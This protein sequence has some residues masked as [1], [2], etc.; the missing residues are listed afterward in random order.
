KPVVHRA[1]GRLDRVRPGGVA[2][3]ELP[4]G[5]NDVEHPVEEVV[6]VGDVPVEGHRL[7]TELVTE[8]PHR[9]RL[10]ARPGGELDRGL[11]DAISAEWN[12]C[13]AC[14]RLD[15]FTV[16]AYLTP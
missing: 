8:A 15:E 14:H 9:H 13:L 10:D 11:E 5:E 3:G 6:L 12:P 2:V 4:L 16:Y 7:E 1:R